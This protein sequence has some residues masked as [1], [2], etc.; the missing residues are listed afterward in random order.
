MQKLLWNF[1]YSYKRNQQVI[2]HCCRGQ[3]ILLEL[4]QMQMYLGNINPIHP[5]FCCLLNNIFPTTTPLD[6]DSFQDFLR[7]QKHNQINNYSF[8][9]III[10]KIHNILRIYCQSLPVSIVFLN[11]WNLEETVS[12]LSELML[13]IKPL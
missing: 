6:S 5:M 2:F 11:I 7:M 4:H 12:L 13:I 9:I 3:L 8:V 1:M 10:Y